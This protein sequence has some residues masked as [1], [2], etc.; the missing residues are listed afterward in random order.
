MAKDVEKALSKVPKEKSSF[1][2]AKTSANS[3]S[4][5]ENA[6]SSLAI[7]KANKKS[8]RKG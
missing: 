8:T 7:A 4:R 2:L 3:C 5:K 1:L 6:E